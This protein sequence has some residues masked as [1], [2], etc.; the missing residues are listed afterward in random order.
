MFIHCCLQIKVMELIGRHPH[1]AYMLAHGQ[2]QFFGHEN[3][4]VLLGPVVQHLTVK[5]SLAVCLQVNLL[6]CSHL[7]LRTQWGEGIVAVWWRHLCSFISCC[8]PCSILLNIAHNNELVVA[9]CDV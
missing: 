5:D 9:G 6:L 7:S 4:A 3:R 8:S 1:L 2:C